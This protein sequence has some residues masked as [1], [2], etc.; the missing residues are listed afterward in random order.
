MPTAAI[1]KDPDYYTSPNDFQP[2]R[3]YDLRNASLDDLNRHQFTSTS[4]NSL[5]FGH[6]KF[7]CLGRFFAA[8]QIKLI[9]CV[10][11]MKYHFCWPK[12][13][14]KRPR[15]IYIDE[16]IGPDRE[17]VVRFRLRRDMDAKCRESFLK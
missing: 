3:F 6:G 10:L 16:R 4:A 15:N 11:I 5:S 1:A 12:G 2:W 7:S 9:L 13:Q 8:G 14:T 17:Q